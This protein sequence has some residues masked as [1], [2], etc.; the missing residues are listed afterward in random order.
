V[1]YLVLSFYY[2]GRCCRTSCWWKKHQQRREKL[3]IMLIHSELSCF[4]VLLFG[5]LLS[6]ELLV[7][8]IPTTAGK[9]FGSCRVKTGLA[10]ALFFHSSSVVSCGTLRTNG[11]IHR[12]SETLYAFIG[13]RNASL[14][15]QPVHSHHKSFLYSQ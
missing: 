10:Q 9:S 1:S 2:S 6:H 5:T 4:V 14:N 12:T 13:R 11:D 8:K 15:L 7:E 3:D